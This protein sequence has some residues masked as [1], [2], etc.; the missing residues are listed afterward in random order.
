MFIPL[1][2][3]VIKIELCFNFRLKYTILPDFW[4][5]GWQKWN[6]TLIL[7]KTQIIPSIPGQWHTETGIKPA[8]HSLVSFSCLFSFF[9]HFFF[10]Q[11]ED[12]RVLK[13]VQKKFCASGPYTGKNR[14]KNPNFKWIFWFLLLFFLP[15]AAILAWIMWENQRKS[16]VGPHPL[17][18]S[19]SWHFLPQSSF[20]N[21]NFR[22]RAGLWFMK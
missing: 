5:R 10:L 1:A 12:D 18:V 19:I 6:Y 17:V 2:L 13:L 20:K 14:K 9:F 21:G 8:N 22:A 16:K 3:R 7:G 11:Q 4:I 15:K